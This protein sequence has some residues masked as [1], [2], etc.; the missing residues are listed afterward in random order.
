MRAGP[1][2]LKNSTASVVMVTDSFSLSLQ[3]YR[4]PQVVRYLPGLRRLIP[5]SGRSEMGLVSS[6]CKNLRPWSDPAST[7]NGANPD[8]SLRTSIIA[9]SVFAPP[10]KSPLTERYLDGLFDRQDCAV[11][12]GRGKR[13]PSGGV[14]VSFDRPAEVSIVMV[15]T[16]T[17]DIRLSRLR[18]VIG[19]NIYS[20]QTQRLLSANTEHW[21][22][23][24]SSVLARPRTQSPHD[25][26]LWIRIVAWSAVRRDYE[27]D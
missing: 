18:D 24:L 2:S 4:F 16:S 8:P 10:V 3:P 26:V 21:H 14:S 12:P 6:A 11:S 15:V 22:F 27:R 5:S 23:E 1:S 17:P 25:A 7:T 9:V 19:T 13:H 20:S